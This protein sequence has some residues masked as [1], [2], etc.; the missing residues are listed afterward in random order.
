MMEAQDGKF[1]ITALSFV[2]WTENNHPG[3]LHKA[4]TTTVLQI[5]KLGKETLMGSLEV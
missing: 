3:G 2:P 5:W 1:K 4:M